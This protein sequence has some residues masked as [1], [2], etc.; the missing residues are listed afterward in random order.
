MLPA[1]KGKRPL[2]AL[3]RRR[4]CRNE[5]RSFDI[6][7][8]CETGPESVLARTNGFRKSD[9]FDST[10]VSARA[11]RPEI[12]SPGSQ[13]ARS[14]QKETCSVD[15]CEK[16]CL[17]GFEEVFDEYIQM[18]RQEGLKALEISKASI[19]LEVHQTFAGQIND[20][21]QAS[22]LLEDTIREAKRDIE[23]AF[24]QIQRF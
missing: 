12:R 7:D 6:T 19:T 16:G 24:Y 9:V 3:P 23:Y 2:T 13:G 22:K 14:S 15:S 21:Q 8:E 1:L 11:P 18:I 4:A 17:N 20:L 10:S 5:S